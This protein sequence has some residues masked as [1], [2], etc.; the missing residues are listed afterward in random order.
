MRTQDYR[1]CYL[2]YNSEKGV[3]DTDDGVF[4]QLL[5]K[6]PYCVQYRSK[7]NTQAFDLKKARQLK[8]WCRQYHI[9]F[10]INDNLPLCRRVQADGLHIGQDDGKIEIVKKQ[11]NWRIPYFTQFKRSPNKPHPIMG[12][13]CYNHLSLSIKAKQK[14]ADYIAF[15]A[16]F[17]SQTKPK[18]ALV[19][20]STVQKAQAL[21]IPVVAIGG[22]T[23]A[24]LTLAQK[25]HAQAYAMIQ[26]V[27]TLI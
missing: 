4:I 11:L 7:E 8:G 20:L 27:N 26:G 6:K 9:P 15:G 24:N 16:L 1:Q 18:K 22:I 23:A 13:S 3:C 12:V 17:P 21:G 14:G 2:I 5:K 19:S 10:I 25:T